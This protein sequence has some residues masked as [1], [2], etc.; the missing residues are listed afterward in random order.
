MFSSLS[1]SSSGA[2]ALDA[3]EDFARARRAHLTA[4]AMQWATGRR[5]RTSHPRTLPETAPWQGRGARM[6]VI[7]LDAIVGTA[8]PSPHFDERFRPASPHLRARWERVA[9]AHRTGV[10][11]PPI[12]VVERPDGY[13]V[14]DGRHRVSVAR[15]TGRREID[16]WVR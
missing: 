12:T 2:P 1:T 15:A 3:R 7:A 14:V 5:R 8:D 9:H 16:A 10:A 4:R 13:Y 11:L 6:E